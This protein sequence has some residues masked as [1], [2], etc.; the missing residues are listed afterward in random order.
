[1]SANKTNKKI[2]LI[3]LENFSNQETKEICAILQSVLQDSYTYIPRIPDL[4]N[5]TLYKFY[6]DKKLDAHTEMIVSVAEMYQFYK[7]EIETVYQ[8][9]Q[10]LND[11]VKYH[12]IIT[13]NYFDSI[14]LKYLDIQF[15]NEKRQV[16]YGFQYIEPSLTFIKYVDEKENPLLNKRIGDLVM[17]KPKRCKIIHDVNRK[18]IIEHLVYCLKHTQK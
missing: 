16:L 8:K 15:K 1:M 7:D 4:F 6:R 9:V 11:D 14:F 2:I 17:N 10:S 13:D 3:N 18:E 5:N 12:V